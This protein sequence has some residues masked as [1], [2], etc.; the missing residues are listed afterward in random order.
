M[1]ASQRGHLLHQIHKALT[2]NH[3]I[4][5]NNLH[6]LDNGCKEFERFYAEYDVNRVT[7]ANG[8]RSYCK[9]IGIMIQNISEICQQPKPF[10]K[11][12]MKILGE[13]HALSNLFLKQLE[14]GKIIRSKGMEYS[15]SMSSDLDRK[16][17]ANAHFTEAEIAPF[18][19]KV[20]FF[21]LKQDFQTEWQKTVSLF[22]YMGLSSAFQKFR[23]MTSK[24]FATRMQVANSLR[25]D[26]GFLKRAC[27]ITQFPINMLFKWKNHPGMTFTWV[28]VPVE[29]NRHVITLSGPD[30]PA[31]LAEKYRS[32]RTVKCLLIAP[33][34]R[35][36]GDHLVLHTHGGGFLT[37]SPKLEAA[38]CAE[39]VAALGVSFLLPQ[40][41]LAPEHPY[42]AAV[43]DVLDIYMFLVSSAPHVLE[44][45][46]FQPKKVLLSGAS[47]G[48]TISL[49]VIFALNA[50][51]K[52]GQTTSTINLMMPCGLNLQFPGTLLAF[53]PVPSSIIFEF[54]CTPALM[55]MSAGFYQEIEPKLTDEQ[56][57]LKPNAKH[58]MKRLSARSLDPLYN[59]LAF[60]EWE[61][62]KDIPLSVLSCEMDPLLDQAVLL[63]KKWVGHKDFDLAVGMPHGFIISP[64]IAVKN[65]SQIVI[66]RMAQVFK[67]KI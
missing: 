17:I 16:I 5:L 39:R 58:V 7:P 2:G 46:G 37:G 52:R 62:L 25:P 34:E 12:N 61:E 55:L 63:T 3:N 48:G 29:V 18:F 4:L 51:R 41:A 30:R 6:Q 22:H 20:G 1:D 35:R 33:K 49:A 45:I 59:P 23:Y 31:F 50:I 67:I 19:G 43:Q 21:N 64:H 66:N 28:E 11:K 54:T 53:I 42:P 40:Y 14:A 32:I 10:T 65:D 9:I 44:L 8:F 60:D 56:W 15:L 36:A 57:F 47:A 24:A 13:Y 38:C 27:D 26:L